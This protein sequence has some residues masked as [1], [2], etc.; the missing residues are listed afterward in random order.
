MLAALPPEDSAAQRTIKLEQASL[1]HFIKE[2]AVLPRHLRKRRV[3]WVL[4][5]S[6]RRSL[7]LFVALAVCGCI[8]CTQ[9][10]GPSDE[11]IP[12][13]VSAD[14]IL[15]EMIRT[16]EQASSYTDRGVVRLR[17]KLDGHWVQD[18]G[19][20]AVTFARPNKLHARAYQ[21]TLTS[22]G[23]QMHAAIADASTENFDGQVVSRPAPRLLT[24]D[25]LYEDPMIL[26]VM[27]GGMG[28]PPASLE[29]LLEEKPLQSVFEAGVTR[30]L[31]GKKEIR[32][33]PCHRVKITLDTGAL[34]FWVDCQSHL[35][36]RLEYPT[37]EL[38]KQM[39]KNVDCTDVTLTAEFRDARIDEPINDDAFCFEMP[40]EAKIVRR[41]VVPPQS[42]PTE[43]LGQ[44]PDDFH[45]TDLDGEA[46]ARDSLLGKVIVL[47]WFN[48]HPASQL[49]LEQVTSA[50]AKFADESRVS[51]HAV[52]TEPSEVGTQH[53]ERLREQWKLGFPVVRDLEAFGRD[54]FA[55]PYAPTTVVLDSRGMVQIY[56]VGANP[57]LAQQ[58][59]DML[60]QLLDGEDLA[61]KIARQCEQERAEYEKALAESSV[62]NS[63]D[64]RLIELP[65]R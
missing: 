9:D 26:N 41:F 16:Y 37:A 6:Y 8:G 18:E 63:E 57:E 58:L 4:D 49:G 59:P 42:L 2:L 61:G 33:R 44:V 1:V 31:L 14:E 35:V 62:P 13:E 53:L 51:F 22:D 56:E 21:L 25:D 28:G 46:V 52:C 10:P 24:L 19:K 12:A 50:Y 3:P 65:L 47:V 32:Q 40:A 30:E 54:V 11:P 38:A 48:D 5:L 20:L 23:R 27:A 7:G 15:E 36:R 55:I 60:E 43:M 34:V 17:Y 64:A 39:A 29:L 45:F